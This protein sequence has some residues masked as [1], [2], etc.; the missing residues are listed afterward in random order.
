MVAELD[1]TMVVI[2]TRRKARMPQITGENEKFCDRPAGFVSRS[3]R[4]DVLRIQPPNFEAA[5]LH[6]L[7]LEPANADGWEWGGRPEAVS[8]PAQRLM[9]L[10]VYRGCDKYSALITTRCC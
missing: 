4:D 6:H 5:R 1:A 7:H 9:S 10:C 2:S 8:Q 3:Q